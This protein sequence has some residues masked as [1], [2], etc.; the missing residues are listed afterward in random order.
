MYLVSNDGT[1]IA[2]CRKVLGVADELAEFI[3]K[4]VEYPALEKAKETKKDDFEWNV[5]YG[6]LMSL[7][8]K[9]DEADN[10][11]AKALGQIEGKDK[12]PVCEFYYEYAAHAIKKTENAEGEKR[13]AKVLELDN[14]NALGFYV[15]AV[16]L[17]FNIAEQFAA[18]RDYDKILEYI[19][20]VIAADNDGKLDLK[21]NALLSK[22]GLIGAQ[23]KTDEALKILDELAKTGKKNV[24]RANALLLAGR[25]YAMDKQYVKSAEKFEEIIQKYPGT[26]E[27][28]FAG[29]F[30]KQVKPLAEKEKAEKGNPP[31][32]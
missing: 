24:L 23:R 12:K 6:A 16:K 5:K 2:D 21:E 8:G 29:N 1:V 15:K 25:I 22:A 3:G 28:D 4:W 27:A 14:G 20:K 32:K 30:A 10:C 26:T 13:I 9:L 18:K 11:F 19:E 31:K 17:Y 7:S